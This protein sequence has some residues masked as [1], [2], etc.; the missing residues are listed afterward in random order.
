MIE[1]PGDNE[2][3]MNVIGIWNRKLN[4]KRMQKLSNI[5]F[6]PYPVT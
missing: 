6:T 2:S 4:D 5:V 3:K 1:A